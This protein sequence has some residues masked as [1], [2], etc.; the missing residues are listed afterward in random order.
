MV[1]RISSILKCCG[2]INLFSFF[3]L[4]MN[5][6]VPSFYGVR[7]IFEVNL[8][9]T[10]LQFTTAPNSISFIIAK[11]SCSN[12]V[13]LNALF[14]GCTIWVTGVLNGILKPLTSFKTIGIVIDCQRSKKYRSLPRLL[15]LAIYCDPK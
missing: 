7:K 10:S 2:A 9:G 3:K 5:L 1:L 8:L 11:F 15:L 4:R 13:S 6:F 12:S 14:E